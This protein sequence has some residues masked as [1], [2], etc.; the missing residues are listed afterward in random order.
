MKTHFTTLFIIFLTAALAIFGILMPKFT[1]LYQNDTLITQ[2]EID[3]IDQVSLSYSSDNDIINIL[4]IFASNNYSFIGDEREIST[5][6]SMQ[7]KNEVSYFLEC[8]YGYSEEFYISYGYLCSYN[9]VSFYS[10]IYGPY[11]FEPCLLHYENDNEMPLDDYDNEQN[12]NSAISGAMSAVSTNER[13]IW[14]VTTS[15]TIESRYFTF[16][17]DDA[18]DKVC[19]FYLYNRPSSDDNYM[20]SVDI[21]KYIYIF[22]ELFTDYYGLN[23]ENC[24]SDAEDSGYDVESTDGILQLY[25]CDLYYTLTDPSDSDNYVTIIISVSSNFVAFNLDSIYY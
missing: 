17:I 21:N 8:L 18:T 7:I 6:D 16:Y 25:E 15:E 19:S 1:S 4:Q 3:D 22:T 13:A 5:D 9:T 10:S 24:Q 2:V 23:V 12:G 20:T 11:S 14:V